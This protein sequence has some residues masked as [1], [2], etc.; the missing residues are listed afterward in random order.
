MLQ[1]TSFSSSRMGGGAVC[2]FCRLKLTIGTHRDLSVPWTVTLYSFKNMP[3]PKGQAAWVC[4]HKDINEWDWSR[5]RQSTYNVIQPGREQG[6]PSHGHFINR[7]ITA[8]YPGQHGPFRR[9]AMLTPD[10]RSCLPGFGRLLPP[11]PRCGHR[12]ALTLV[13]LRC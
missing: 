13:T 5:E 11:F 3:F 7:S 8:W 6:F 12:G 9:L 1:C 10:R 4:F 2:F